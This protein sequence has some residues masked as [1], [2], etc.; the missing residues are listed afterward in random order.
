MR[1]AV[2]AYLDG[3]VDPVTAAV[4]GAHLRRCWACSGEAE[5]IRMIKSS[6]RNLAG[7]DDD[8]LAVMRLRRRFDGAG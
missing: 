8:V 6:L 4:V 2:S 5:L 1:R 3:E 7:R